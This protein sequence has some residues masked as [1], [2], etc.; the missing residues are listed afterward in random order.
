VEFMPGRALR[1]GSVR[2]RL[3]LADLSLSPYQLTSH[4]QGSVLTSY[5]KSALNIRI[6]VATGE[7]G[8]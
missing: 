8:C 1:Y 7:M 6:P 4:P 3:S 5:V 2:V